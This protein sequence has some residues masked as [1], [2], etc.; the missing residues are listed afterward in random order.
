MG[1]FDNSEDDYH[2]NCRPKDITI[3]FDS[4]SATTSTLTD[5]YSSWQ[6]VDLSSP[7]DTKTVTITINS[8]YSG[9]YY[10]DQAISEV[11]FS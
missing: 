2:K 5:S 8:F 3:S 6:T 11:Q 4:G 7:V 9:N 10:H 1:G